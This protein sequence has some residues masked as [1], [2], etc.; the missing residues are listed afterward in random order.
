MTQ[1]NVG[2]SS[3]GFGSLSA[4]TDALFVVFAVD[5]AR[6]TRGERRRRGRDDQWWGNRTSGGASVA[7]REVR[8]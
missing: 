2:I 1:R 6:T 8:A 7:R 5:M 3:R 4:Q